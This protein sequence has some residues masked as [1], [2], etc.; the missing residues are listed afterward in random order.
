M[1]TPTALLPIPNTLVKEIM[2]DAEGLQSFLEL[3]SGAEQKSIKHIILDI[4]T[5]EQ[6]KLKAKLKDLDVNRPCDVDEKGIPYRIPYQSTLL[7]LAAR[8][9]FVDLIH[10]LIAQGA[11]LE[12]IDNYGYTPLLTAIANRQLKAARTLLS[13]NANVHAVTN[14]KDLTNHENCTNHQLTTLMIAAEKNLDSLIPDLLAKK[15]DLEA[16]CM[17]GST[18]LVK[19][20]THGC[21]PAAQTLL[22]HKANVNTIDGER[23]TPLHYVIQMYSI[24]VYDTITEKLVDYDTI[25]EE[26]IAR[27]ANCAAINQYKH[28]P[29]MYAKSHQAVLLLKVEGLLHLVLESGHLHSFANYIECLYLGTLPHLSNDH[30]LTTDRGYL[31]K[32]VTV[33]LAAASRVF[34]ETRQAQLNTLIASLNAEAKAEAEAKA[35][36]EAEV[37]PEFPVPIPISEE[38]VKSVIVRLM[39]AYIMVLLSPR[40]A[41]EFWRPYREFVSFQNAQNNSVLPENTSPTTFPVGILPTM[42][43]YRIGKPPLSGFSSD[44]SS[45][46]LDRANEQWTTL[47]TK[48]MNAAFRML[49][50]TAASPR[51]DDAASSSSTPPP[52]VPTPT[53]V[54]VPTIA[55]ASGPAP[56]TPLY[57]ATSA[58]QKT[59]LEPSPTT[60]LNHPYIKMGN[61]V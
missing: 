45:L 32:L 15:V 40:N 29:L 33:Q 58:P 42:L 23:S 46:C 22:A 8:N 56:L 10:M 47:I 41:A 18:A 13:L 43:E 21:F 39:H 2:A 44:P 53:P 50:P 48:R 24:R 38:A 51:I 3:N 34:F 59:E 37:A 54:V 28:T 14:F 11:N 31:E 12:A 55:T 19:A 1:S 52:V 6:N 60:I 16:K 61:S 17:F 20:L 26:L 9:G 27:G 4:V 36:A 35:A 5:Y 57:N 49:S 25:T 30:L 7:I